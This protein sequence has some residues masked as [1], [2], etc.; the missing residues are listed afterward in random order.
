ML[1]FNRSKLGIVLL[2][3]PAQ[4]LKVLVLTPQRLGT[5]PIYGSKYQYTLCTTPVYYV[6]YLKKA[7]YKVY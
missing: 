7:N 2:R 5:K 6:K 1:S 4:A 3:P